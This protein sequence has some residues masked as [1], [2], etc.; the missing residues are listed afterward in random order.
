MGEYDERA[1]MPQGESLNP[2]DMFEKRIRV[3]A[4]LFS[5]GC[6][7]A[8][9]LSELVGVSVRS[10]YRVST[11]PEH[12]LYPVWHSELKAMGYS[13]DLS[14]RVKPRGRQV[15]KGKREK[16]RAGWRGLK[17]RYPGMSRR[18]MAARLASEVGETQSAVIGW[19]RGF[20][21]DEQQGL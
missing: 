9:R 17:K 14:F 10:L 2:M 4:F 8:N 3:A 11:N 1:L 6:R 18:G 5:E 12:R 16:A 20:E 13:G 15:D 19:L 7:D 21:K